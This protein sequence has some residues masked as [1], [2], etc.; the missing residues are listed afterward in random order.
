MSNLGDREKGYA[1]E[2]DNPTNAFRVNNL[3]IVPGFDSMGDL[4]IVMYFINKRDLI[5]VSHSEA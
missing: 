2:V 1:M 5:P 4:R 3:M